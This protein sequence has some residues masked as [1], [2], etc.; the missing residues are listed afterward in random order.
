MKCT[1]VIIL[2]TLMLLL[3]GCTKGELDETRS[4]I[5]VPPIITEEPDYDIDP[6]SDDINHEEY[7]ESSVRCVED[8]KN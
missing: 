2:V 1:A 7:T 3:G 6:L 4:P 8:S 5:P